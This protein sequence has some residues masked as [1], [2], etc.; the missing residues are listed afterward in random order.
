MSYRVTQAFTDLQDNNY[1]YAVGDTY[2]H[3][4]SVVSPK[5]I[6]ELASSNNRRGIAVIE[7]LEK[8]VEPEPISTKEAPSEKTTDKRKRV[9]KNAVRNLS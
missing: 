7:V 1:H 2:P 5:R 6:A 3:S 9:R 8:K 4:G